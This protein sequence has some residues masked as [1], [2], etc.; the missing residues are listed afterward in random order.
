M[1]GTATWGDVRHFVSAALLDKGAPENFGYAVMDVAIKLV[2]ALII[3]TVAI[4]GPK[5]EK[6]TPAP[7][8]RSPTQPVDSAS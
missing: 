3:L 4:V 8:L 6:R 7:P 2:I 1:T 5:K